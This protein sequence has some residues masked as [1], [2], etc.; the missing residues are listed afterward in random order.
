VVR[1]LLYKCMSDPSNIQHDLAVCSQAVD[2]SGALD[3]QGFRE[4]ILQNWMSWRGI[5]WADSDLVRVR[6]NNAVVACLKAKGYTD[7]QIIPLFE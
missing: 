2:R 1:A 5:S 7:T 6:R 3:P 4:G